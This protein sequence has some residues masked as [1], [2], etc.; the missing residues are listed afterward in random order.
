MCRVCSHPIPETGKKYSVA[1][2]ASKLKILYDGFDPDEEDPDVNSTVVCNPCYKAVPRASEERKKIIASNKKNPK[3]PQKQFT[4][5]ATLPTSMYIVGHNVRLHL[6]TGCVCDQYSEAGVTVSA[7]SHSSAPALDSSSSTSAPSRSGG[8]ASEV[9]DRSGPSQRNREQQL[10]VSDSPGPTST[11]RRS[12]VTPQKRIDLPAANE[13]DDETPTKLLRL[14]AEPLESPSDKLSVR[15]RRK[16]LPQKISMKFETRTPVP[17]EGD[18][19]TLVEEVTVSK[20]YVAEDSFDIDRMDKKDIAEVFAC[21]ICGRFPKD[22][23]VSAKCHH[24]FC[25]VC[26]DNFKS[27]VETS[28]CP[29]VDCKVKLR[30]DD[31]MPIGG[32][33]KK[34]HRTMLI[35]CRNKGCK[36]LFNVDQ[37]D[38]HQAI[39]R[40][41]REVLRE[42]KSKLSDTRSTV[43]LAEANQM[44]EKV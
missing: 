20:V 6:L 30:H 42:R 2:L 8:A 41:F 28:K 24:S 7:S 27:N 3:R 5:P 10:T 19:D 12:L 23:S 37:I 16:H 11:P 4:M 18:E 44:I 17:S 25:N 35:T 1:S 39:C 29:A 31:L 14:S 43:I 26:L 9:S 36:E 34:V 33:A 32:W 22:G 13:S 38:D 21:K 40:K 15:E